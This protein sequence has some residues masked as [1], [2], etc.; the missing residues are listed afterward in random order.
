LEPLL[1][2]RAELRRAHPTRPRRGGHQTGG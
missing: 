1:A 2:R